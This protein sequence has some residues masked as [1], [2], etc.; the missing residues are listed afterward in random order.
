MSAPRLPG[1]VAFITG[2]SSGIGAAIAKLFASEG[3]KVVLTARTEE[4]LKKIGAEINASGGTAATI[5][6]DVTQMDDMR[7]AVEFAT[8]T[9]GTVDILVNSAG[10]IKR[11]E[12]IEDATDEDFDWQMD[13]NVRGVFH[14]TKF[15]LPVMMKQGKGAIVNIGSVSSFIATKGYATYCATKG[16]V[17]SYTRVV[18]LQYAEHGI[19]ANV[20]E[21]AGIHTPLAYMDRPNYEDGLEEAIKRTDPIARIGQPED[22]AYAALFL[23]SD[24]SSWI[25]GQS[26]VVDGGASIK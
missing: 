22:V 13:I 10:V 3:A 1:K 17:M 16:A 24:E 20:V 2:G 15:C 8:Y 23:A 14:T 18:A 5:T 7:R 11:T 6:G 4:P 26:I 21:P 12:V 19:R 9:F 25:T